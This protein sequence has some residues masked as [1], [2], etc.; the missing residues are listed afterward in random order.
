MAGLEIIFDLRETRFPNSKSDLPLESP[1]FGF[2]QNIASFYGVFVKCIN[3][4]GY[5]CL[6]R[7]RNILWECYL[8]ILTLQ[9]YRKRYAEIQKQSNFG[10]HLEING[11]HL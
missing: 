6:K 1:F 10:G 4:D 2:S 11:R 8:M 9:K 5:K 3:L 7:F